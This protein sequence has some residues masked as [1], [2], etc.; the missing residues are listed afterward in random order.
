M[1][2]NFLLVNGIQV[3]SSEVP[4]GNQNQIYRGKKKITGPLLLFSLGLYMLTFGLCIFG[5]LTTHYEF[6]NVFN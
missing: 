1:A 6:E 5:K 3:C 2:Q 4:N